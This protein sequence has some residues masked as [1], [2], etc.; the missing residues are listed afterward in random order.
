MEWGRKV[1]TVGVK[2]R[3]VI[4][5]LT[6]WKRWIWALTLLALLGGGLLW[7]ASSRKSEPQNS[8]PVY[9]AVFVGTGVRV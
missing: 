7:A 6:V 9:G 3:Q 1:K 5:M 8:E 2:E 4:H